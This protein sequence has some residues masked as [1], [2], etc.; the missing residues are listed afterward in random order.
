MLWG[1][2]EIWIERQKKSDKRPE[3]AHID[4]ICGERKGEGKRNGRLIKRKIS[5]EEEEK[6]RVIKAGVNDCSLWME[7]KGSAREGH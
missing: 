5:K 3:T 1:E 7:R 2:E 6:M 4:A